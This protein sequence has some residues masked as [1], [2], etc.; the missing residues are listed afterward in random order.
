MVASKSMPH[1]VMYFL[2]HEPQYRREE[3]EFAPKFSEP[4]MWMRVRHSQERCGDIIVIFA[5]QT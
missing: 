4:S 2:P 1:R 3:V 5:R